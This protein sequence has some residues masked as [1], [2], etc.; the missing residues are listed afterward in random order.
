M[1]EEV[2]VAGGEVQEELSSRES[3]LRTR[4]DGHPEVLTDFDGGQGVADAEELARGE[5][6][7]VLA[8]IADMYAVAG[9]N[10]CGSEPA[11]FVELAVPGQVSLRDDAENAAS[12]RRNGAVVEPAGVADGG[13]EDDH[14]AELGR[15]GD[16]LL[17]GLLRIGEQ[18]VL[19][20][21]IG[22]GVARDAQ[23]REYDHGR[24]LRGQL[25]AELENLPGVRRR[26]GHVHARH[27]RR[28]TDQSKVL[29]RRKDSGFALG[30]QERS[31][32]YL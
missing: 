10:V 4:G 17:D 23:L 1:L 25:L 14:G 29:H 6:D 7:V 22:A 20:E 2:F 32:P 11:R 19:A 15:L 28:H 26:V 30:L 16:D 8:R 27:R 18:A 31:F 13:A 24:Q 9:K 5:P 21:K 12:A 3:G